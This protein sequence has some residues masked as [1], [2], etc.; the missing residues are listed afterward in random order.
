MFIVELIPATLLCS[1]ERH[2]YINSVGTATALPNQA[3]GGWLVGYKHRT[4]AEWSHDVVF[5]ASD[6]CKRC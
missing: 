4:P 3:G 6:S 5:F 2:S 1:E